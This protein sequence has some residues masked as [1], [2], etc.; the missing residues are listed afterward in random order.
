MKSQIDWYRGGD[1]FLCEFA[2][3]LPAPPFFMLI[4][5]ELRV[6]QDVPG[7]ID[8]FS[9]S[10]P[11]AITWRGPDGQEI[12]SWTDTQEYTPQTWFWF[13]PPGTPP[14]QHVFTATQ[15]AVTTQWSF[16]IELAQEE[17]V[18]RIPPY[19]SQPFEFAF[20]GFEGNEEV[21]VF[22]YGNEDSF[23]DARRY[24]TELPSVVVDARG[25]AIYSIDIGSG[26]AGEY[27][28]VTERMIN[29]IP[30]TVE[31]GYE[32]LQDPC[33]SGPTFSL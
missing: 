4:E 13:V 22:L 17:K 9:D 10:Q 11:I 14:G 18:A 16:T 3:R 29:S 12:D 2:D 25:E 15:G 31:L 21:R 8:G 26:S 19:R 32:H 6:G 7:C 1:G 24:I 30:E 23:A 5:D 33:W 27:C 20:V 28:I